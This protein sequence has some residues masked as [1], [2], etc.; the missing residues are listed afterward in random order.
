METSLVTPSR[1]LNGQPTWRW[2][3]SQVSAEFRKVI[4]CQR[5]KPL[6][7]LTWLLIELRAG[8]RVFKLAL[9]PDEHPTDVPNVPFLLG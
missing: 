7:D 2:S 3:P 1:P 4:N 6:Q 8:E 9:D 5:Q